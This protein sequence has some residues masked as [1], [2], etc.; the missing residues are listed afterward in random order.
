MTM[1]VDMIQKL[2]ASLPKKVEAARNLLNRPM[3]YAEKILYSHLRD[4]PS[5]AYQRGKDYVDFGP[6]RVALFARAP[7]TRTYRKVEI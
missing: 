4:I 2:Y 3:T 1:N 5:N 7:G 6:D